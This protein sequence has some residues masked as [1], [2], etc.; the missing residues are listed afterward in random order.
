M[1][2]T[3]TGGR[4]ADGVGT[5]GR[6]LKSLLRKLY[7]S[8]GL[9]AAVFLAFSVYVDA[10]LMFRAFGRFDWRAGAVALLL[11]AVNYVTRFWRWHLYLKH[12][13]ARVPVIE[14]FRIFLSG[15]A[16]SVTPGKAGELVKAYMVRQA[17][18]APVGLG[19]SAVF[20]ER[21]TD[22]VALLILSTAGIYGLEE[23]AWTLGLSAAGISAIFLVIFVPGAIPM[24]LRALDAVPR[25]HALVGPIRDAYENARRLL[26]PG[27]LARGL[28]IGVVAWLAECVGFHYVLKGFGADVGVGPATFIYAFSTIFGALTLLPGG[29]GT[30][31]GSMTGLLT[32]EGLTVADAAAATFLIRACT[33]WFAVAIGAVVLVRSAVSGDGEELDRAT[34]EAGEGA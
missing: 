33:L 19:V 31:E 30:T 22:F 17:S 32:L 9:G 27:M 1:N 24:L 11:A 28:S 20:A 5:G 6:G 7:L 26:M 14:S 25:L 34:S 10:G 8:I 12:L 18:G 13:G 4:T 29:I 21:L 15:L 3:E 16:L 23:G 2:I